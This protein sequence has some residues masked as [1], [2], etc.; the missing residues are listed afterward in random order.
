MIGVSLIGIVKKK[1]IMLIIRAREA[2][3]HQRCSAE[4]AINK[5]LHVELPCDP[6]DRDGSA[7][8]RGA[9]HDRHRHRIGNT[10]DRSDIPSWVVLFLSQLLTFI[11]RRRLLYLDRFRLLGAQRKETLLSWEPGPCP[12]NRFWRVIVHL[13][14][15]NF[16]NPREFSL[17]G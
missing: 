9:S 13:A 12:P 14:S 5:A 16:F 15:V 11:R 7:A 6:N 17:N 3:R 1:R 10:P 8:R 4:T 2:E